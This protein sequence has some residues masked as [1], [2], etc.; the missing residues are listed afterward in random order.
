MNFPAHRK[1]SA[2]NGYDALNVVHGES[3]ISSNN[4]AFLKIEVFLEFKWFLLCFPNRLMTVSFLAT[5][6]FI[7]AK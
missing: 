3:P 5:D 2:L 6:L 4:F 7:I 1:N